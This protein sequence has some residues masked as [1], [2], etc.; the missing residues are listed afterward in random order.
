M[1]LIP[2]RTAVY[3]ILLATFFML[4]VMGCS[5]T[6]S[7]PGNYKLERWEDNKTYYLL[8][9]STQDAKGGGLIDGTVLRIA[10]SDEVIFAER[11]STFRGDPDGWMLIDIK[12]GKVSGPISESE[13]DIFL[14]KYHLQVKE[15]GQAWNEL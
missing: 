5:D 3:R 13:C 7:L 9:P 12:S 1:R 10:W 11:L 8:G 4:G 2:M 6:K 14:K 15:V